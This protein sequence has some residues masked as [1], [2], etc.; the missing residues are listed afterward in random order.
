[1]AKGEELGVRP[2]RR[3]PARLN[4]LFQ[5][6]A[7]FQTETGWKL[8]LVMMHLVQI[9]HFRKARLSVLLFAPN[10][11]RHTYTHNA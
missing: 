11:A 10:V 4:S 1:M 3:R 7:R 6:K 8:E 5:G 9:R 2:R